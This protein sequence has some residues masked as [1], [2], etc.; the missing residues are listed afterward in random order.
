MDTQLQRSPVYQQL[1]DQLRSALASEYECGDRFLTEREIAAQFEVSRA[2]ANK[3]LASLVSEGVL[4]FRRG[5]GTFVR[6]DV[7]DYD[8]QSLVSFTE[9][10]RAAGK[11]PVTELITFG[12][13]SATETSEEIQKAL[14]V[15]GDELLWE[16]ERLRLADGTPVILEHRYIIQQQCPKLTKS[17]AEGSLYRAWTK[18]HGLSIAG[19]DEIIR[20]VL[21]TT[22]EAR[23]LK[24]AAR[25][26]ALEVIAV[27]RLD[28]NSPL[29]WERTLYRGDQYEFHSRLGPIQSATPAR[30]MLREA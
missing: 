6:R 16:L 23:Q 28:N 11:K 7:I 10:A 2:T 17:Q 25:S 13:I 29:W 12:E 21:V 3:A 30:G 22:G 26:P 19:A 24:V 20:A 8:V 14:S 15:S 4:E 18:T 9:K 5:I 27:G 1:N